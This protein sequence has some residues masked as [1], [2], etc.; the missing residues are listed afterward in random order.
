MKK[1]VLLLLFF[2]FNYLVNAQTVITTPGIT[3]LVKFQPISSYEG[4]KYSMA[5]AK[6]IKTKKYSVLIEHTITDFSKSMMDTIGLSM[7]LTV[8][9]SIVRGAVTSSERDKMLLQPA[10]VQPKT[11]TK[12]TVYAFAISDTLLNDIK[13][14]KI[15]DITLINRRSPTS[16]SSEGIATSKTGD[17]FFITNASL[18]N[19]GTTKG[20]FD[21]VAVYKTKPIVLYSMFLKDPDQIS[22][23]L[24]QPT[25]STS[26][27]YLVNT[28]QTL[29]GKYVIVFE[30]QKAT[31]ITLYPTKKF[32]Y[33]DELLVIDKVPFELTGCNCGEFS[34]GKIGS[35]SPKDDGTVGISFSFKD[36]T[37]KDQVIRIFQKGRFVE[38][39]EVCYWRNNI[40]L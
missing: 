4:Q 17:V 10:V 24:G 36:K 12:G 25:K 37:K 11:N 1:T 33:T 16:S 6:D 8:Y 14:Q 3:T 26:E 19:T 13:K 31:W 18:I 21:A 35:N 32:K 34:T 28:Y 23:V 15:W 27:K 22:K 5:I 40:Q 39:V 20:S 7:Q 29:E 2:I 30:D 9:K 38:K